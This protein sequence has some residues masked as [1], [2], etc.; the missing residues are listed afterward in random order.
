LCWHIF[1][2]RHLFREQ[3]RQ[4]EFGLEHRI[5]ALYTSIERRAH[6][7][8]HRVADLTLDVDDHLP[9]IGLIPAPVQVFGRQPELNHEVAGQVLGSDF[10][11]LFAP[12]PD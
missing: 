10:A 6:P 2:G 1:F 11:P 8:Q 5:T 9:G 3:P 4:H 12:K 7:A